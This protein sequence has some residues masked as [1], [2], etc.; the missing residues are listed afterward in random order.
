MVKRLITAA[1]VTA[2]ATAVAS[3]GIA[4]IS[5]LTQ[6]ALHDPPAAVNGILQFFV[7]NLKK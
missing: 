5:N 1:L 4:E 6:Q 2:V 3:G 7:Q